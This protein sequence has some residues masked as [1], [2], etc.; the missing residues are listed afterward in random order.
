MTPTS[1]PQPPKCEYCN[2][3]NGIHYGYCAAAQM[4]S[5]PQ[6]PRCDHKFIDSKSCV[7][8]GWTPK[9]EDFPQPPLVIS[10]E[11]REA[12]VKEYG[13]ERSRSLFNN[14]NAEPSGH[15][16]QLAINQATEK[17]MDTI[18]DQDNK[19][20]KLIKEN[21]SL[22][23]MVETWHTRATAHQQNSEALEKIRQTLTTRIKELEIELASSERFIERNIGN[24]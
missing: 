13:A 3:E 17:L 21:E 4:I 5:S 14:S 9:P 12:A 10:E 19:L 15:F 7:K 22:K 18:L 24:K 6:P 11:A 16:V 20:E 2:G 23:F 1:N 8:C